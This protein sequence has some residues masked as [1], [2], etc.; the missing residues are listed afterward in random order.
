MSPHGMLELHPTKK[1]CLWVHRGLWSLSLCPVVGLN[2]QKSLSPASLIQYPIPVYP[3]V[4][5]SQGFPPGHR[6]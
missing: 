6:L 2:S 3:D 4:A 1:G 5:G